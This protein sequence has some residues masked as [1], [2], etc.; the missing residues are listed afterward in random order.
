L[1]VS[2]TSLAAVCVS[3]TVSAVMRRE[4][5]PCRPSWIYAKV[6]FTQTSTTPKNPNCSTAFNRNQCYCGRFCV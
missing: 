1:A 6:N 4:N 2:V 3:A 5:C